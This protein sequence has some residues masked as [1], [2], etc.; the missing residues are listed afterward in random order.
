MR[1]RAGDTTFVAPALVRGTLRRGLDLARGLAEPL[2]RAIA[3]MFVVP[4]P[5]P[6]ARPVALIVAAEM[7]DDAHVT[8]LVRF[9]I[10]PSLNVPVAVNCCVRPLAIEGFDGVTA[11]DVSVAVA[12]GVARVRLFAL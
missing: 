5:T 4:T 3:V 10:V 8:E 12:G 1:N 7:F 2:Q 11:I 6:V 9:C